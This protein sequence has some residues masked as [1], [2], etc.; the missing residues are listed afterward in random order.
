M[1]FRKIG[2]GYDENKNNNNNHKRKTEIQSK[3]VIQYKQNQIKIREFMK[4]NE[5]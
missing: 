2:I 1:I 3:F 5:L 4:F